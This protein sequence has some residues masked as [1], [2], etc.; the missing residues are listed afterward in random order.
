MKEAWKQVI[1]E[2][3]TLHRAQV[4]KGDFTSLF[5]RA[6][7]RAFTKETI[8]AAFKA[9]GVYPF[10]RTVITAKQMKPS[11]ATS[12]KGQ[13]AVAWT[14]PVRAIMTSFKTYKPTSFDVSPTHVR[15]P[16][17][18]T[19]HTVPLATTPPNPSPKRMRDANID[20]AL[21]T[22][23]TPSKRMRMMTSSLAATSS[24]SFLVSNTKITSAQPV[25]PLVEHVPLHPPEPDWTLLKAPITTPSFYQSNTQLLQ[26][27]EELTINLDLAKQHLDACKE[28]E[29]ANNAQLVI[30]DITLQKMN[31]TLH[32]K[33][34][35]K[36]NKRTK[37]FT[38]GLGRHLTHVETITTV[39]ANEDARALEKNQKEQRQKD[40][41]AKKG[42]K[43]KAEREWKVMV[44]AYAVTVKEWEDECKRLMMERVLKKNLPKKPAR[45]VKPK[46]PKTSQIPNVE[47][48]PSGEPQESDDSSTSSSDGEE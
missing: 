2:F 32:A 33:E 10:D 1:N 26:R 46:V 31:Q 22:P 18:I 38:G 30:Q 17:P 8:E 36:K 47:A 23:E 9:T 25:L 19:T 13:F 37:L 21:M 35:K 29:E 7:R 34:N 14:S 42:Q 24:G 48:G 11:E 12:V 28:I 6:Y 43:E 16:P 4:T 40:R 5:G 20:P 15:P 44:E 39:R 27:V 3:E 41:E 45:P